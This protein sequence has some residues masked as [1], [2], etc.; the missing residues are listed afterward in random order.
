MALPDAGEGPFAAAYSHPQALGQS[1]QSQG[2]GS[3]SAKA[4][5]AWTPTGCA[6]RS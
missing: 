5:A 2:S 4:A 1:R 6:P 3:G